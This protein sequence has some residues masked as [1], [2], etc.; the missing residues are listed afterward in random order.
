[1]R[2][3][4]SREEEEEEEEDEEV[5]D[6]VDDAEPI[7]F[8]FRL[9]SPSCSS[10]RR[11]SLREEGDGDDGEDDDCE[12]E[13]VTKSGLEWRRLRKRRGAFKVDVMPSK[14]PM[15]PIRLAPPAATPAFSRCH[16]AQEERLL[17]SRRPAL[18]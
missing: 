1:V 12:E 3:V 15:L 6:D 8:P 9:A 11:L 14:F 5:D 17:A 16:I 2:R 10:L 7:F 13:A 18:K 4:S